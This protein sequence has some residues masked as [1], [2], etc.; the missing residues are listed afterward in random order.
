MFV[1]NRRCVVRT[2]TATYKFNPGDDIGMLPRGLVDQMVKR[3]N[4]YSVEVIE[5]ETTK[6]EPPDEIGTGGKST[7]KART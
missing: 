5:E 7:K 2:S 6:P 1:A 4:A 3:G